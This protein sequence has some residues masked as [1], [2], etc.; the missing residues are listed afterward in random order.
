MSTS[1]TT[2]VWNIS[3]PPTMAKEAEAVAKKEARTKSELVREALRQYIWS[4]KW[5]RLQTYGRKKA[6]ELGLKEK[7][8]EQMIDEMR[9]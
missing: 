2:K 4:T 5:K 8:I 6:K 7:D 1:R 3:L 9:K